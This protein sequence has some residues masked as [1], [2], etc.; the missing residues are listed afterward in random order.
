MIRM[1]WQGMIEIRTL[2]RTSVAVNG[3]PLTGEAAWPKSLALLVYMA[4]EPGPDRREEILAVLWSDRDER[5]ARRALNQLL[6]T[7]RK[8]NP[9]LDLESVKGA[10]DFGREV[11]LDVEEIERR[12][13]SG[14]LEGAVE[15]YGGPFLADLA[16]NEPEFDHWADRQREDLRRK[17]RRAALD[18]AKQAVS[19][20]DTEAAAAYCRR[21]VNADPLDDEAQHLLIECLHAR[22]DRVGALRQYEAYRD[23]LARELEVEPLDHTRELVARIRGEVG[24]AESAVEGVTAAIPGGGDGGATSAAPEPDVLPPPGARSDRGTR[25]AQPERRGLLWA[26]VAVLIVAAA[27]WVAPKLGLKGTG[28]APVIEAGELRLAVLPFQLHGFETDLEEGLDTGLAQLMALNFEHLGTIGVVGHRSVLDHWAELRS[29]ADVLFNS[30]SLKAFASDVGATAVLV[31]DVHVSSDG[32]WLVA[33]IMDAA[34]GG[35]MAKADARGPRDNLWDL[36]EE[37][38]RSLAAEVNPATTTTAA[39]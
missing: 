23:L 2:G 39:R 21:L 33:D 26:A 20:G 38:A 18:L 9:E 27:L 4:R 7:L 17:F 11:W 14:D 6:Y 22:G 1:V 24:P 12:L 36:V 15:L 37:L 34:S 25:P 35:V 31:G 28:G 3:E 8:A 30:S 13:D 32:Y 5:R 16:I 29:G 10:I 19:A